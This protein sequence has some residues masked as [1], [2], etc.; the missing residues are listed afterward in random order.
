MQTLLTDLPLGR[1]ALLAAVPLFYLLA[2]AGTWVGT[3]AIEPKFPISA[4]F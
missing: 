2:G 4:D 3:S 1:A